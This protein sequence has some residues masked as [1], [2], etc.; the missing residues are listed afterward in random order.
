M[1]LCRGKPFFTSSAHIASGSGLP[2]RCW[3]CSRM[4]F[5][6]FSALRPK[7]ET[8]AKKMRAWNRRYRRWK[9]T[10]VTNFGRDVLEARGRLLQ[11][12]KGDLV[13]K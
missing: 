4:W 10:E 8:L 2:M 7:N 12:F 1:V 9:Y 13:R 11:P 5:C 6:A 3:I